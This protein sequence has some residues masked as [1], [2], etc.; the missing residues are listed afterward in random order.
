LLHQ[1]VT[2]AAAA[3]DLASGTVSSAALTAA[4]LYRIQDI[5]GE[6]A[7]AFIRIYESQALSAA[8]ASDQ[9]RAHRRTSS[10]LAGIPVSVKDL[11]DVAG[12]ATTA[13]SVILSG[14]P[15]ASSNA[16]VVGRLR[17]AGAI[18]V[19]K[20]NMT[21]FAYSTLGLNPHYG[22][23][24]NPYD[25]ARIPGGSSSGAAAAVAY[26]FSMA[27]IGSD[28]G[29]SVRIPAAFCGLVG[30]KPT[31]RRIPRGGMFPLSSS[32]DSVG[33]IAPSVA[34]C[35]LLD[36]IMAGESPRPVLELSVSG[37]RLAIPT[38]H[39]A[40]G[41]DPAV[42][43]AYERALARLRTAGAQTVETPLAGLGILDEIEALGGVI[44]PEAYEVHRSLLEEHRER[45][46]PR[47]RSRLEDSATV[48]KANYL[49][50]IG[51]R[52]VAV[53][54]FDHSTRAFDAVLAP[55]VAIVPPLFRDLD[56]DDDYRRI[57]VEVRRNA[58]AFNMLD[59]CA[60]TLPC[61][62]PGELPVGL[63]IVG[64]RGEDARLLSL[65][66]ALEKVLSL[67]A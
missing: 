67:T 13:G 1:Q 65:G 57:N 32:L 12:E 21:E 2:L 17:A 5:S 43:R 46:D 31:Q 3:A 41:L 38:R 25:P 6:G 8:Q 34:C 64:E 23:P 60:L 62:E 10:P 35:A 24:R 7:R 56:S 49:A 42:G 4:C 59:R 40:E 61:H 58:S 30:F 50:A 18:I 54:A 52:D 48:T 9:L 37:L 63:M 20:T 14:A 47:V 33:P 55:T 26:G 28:T 44:G 51:L 15:H 22:T 53:Q 16:V 39:F 45:Y 19:G 36:A 27:S 66:I 29:G 11:F